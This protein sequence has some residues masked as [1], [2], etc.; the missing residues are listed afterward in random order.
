MVLC[1]VISKILGFLGGHPDLAW[2]WP[3]AAD[4]SALSASA[5]VEETSISGVCCWGHDMRHARKCLRRQELVPPDSR[6]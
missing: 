3:L 1:M 4:V 6:T 5:T 2:F